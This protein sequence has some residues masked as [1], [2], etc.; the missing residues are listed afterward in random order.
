M[1]RGLG[2]ALDCAGLA[3]FVGEVEGPEFSGELDSNFIFSTGRARLGAS[4]A[5]TV[6]SV[7]GAAE[8]S[9]LT[10]A[11]PGLGAALETEAICVSFLP[12]AAVGVDAFAVLRFEVTATGAVAASVEAVVAG[13]ERPFNKAKPGA[14]GLRA[15]RAGFGVLGVPTVLLVGGVA[16]SVPFTG[17]AAAEFFGGMLW[18]AVLALAGLA[19]L[20]CGT[21]AVCAIGCEGVSGAGLS[22]SNAASTVF[23]RFETSATP[24][25]TF[26]F[27]SQ[28]I[29]ISAASL[30]ELSEFL[31]V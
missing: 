1:R 31:G 9:A 11:L 12:L 17:A 7:E 24:G 4:V 5:C 20:F 14:F 6:A 2:A 13:A 21:V 30:D 3:S 22:P 16:F 8:A 27:C 25:L 18:L 19:G 10:A 23:S 29:V 28:A 15:A 26:G